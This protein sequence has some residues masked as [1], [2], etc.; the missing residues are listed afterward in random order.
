[1]QASYR[2]FLVTPLTPRDDLIA[3]IRKKQGELKSGDPKRNVLDQCIAALNNPGP[4]DALLALG[5]YIREQ[6]GNYGQLSSCFFGTLQ[7]RFGVKLAKTD[8]EKL[9]EETM[10]FLECSIDAQLAPAAA[11]VTTPGVDASL[12]SM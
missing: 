6:S 9:V 2:P 8:T 11:P 7:S 10:N 4:T 1:M 12:L 5:M 3:R